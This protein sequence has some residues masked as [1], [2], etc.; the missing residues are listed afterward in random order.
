MFGAILSTTDIRKGFDLLKAALAKLGACATTRETEVVVFGAA[1]SGGNA[2]D[3]CGFRTRFMGHI[4]EETSLALHYSAA[5][6]FV[7]P[8]RIEAL[9]QTVIEAQA[10][11]TPGI[12]FGNSGMSDAILDRA[13]GILVP[14]F[15]VS[16]LASGIGEVL[17]W[18]L[19]ARQRCRAFA[20]KHFNAATVAEQH[21]R[22]YEGVHSGLRLRGTALAAAESL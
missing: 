9:N 6:V 12:A 2:Q 15:D 19:S 11:G 7:A 3:I 16:A 14:A 22:V 13:T 1:A 8:S 17:A 20:E 4:S 18:D 21:L 10:C 5:D